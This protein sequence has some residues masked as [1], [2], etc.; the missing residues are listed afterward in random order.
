[1]TLAP[2]VQ[3]AADPDL[4][5]LVGDDMTEQRTCADDAVTEEERRRAQGRRRPV[6]APAEADVPAVGADGAAA[7][8]A[9]VGRRAVRG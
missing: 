7:G 4:H 8:T 6:G 1:M 2:A 5:D 9:G 3:H